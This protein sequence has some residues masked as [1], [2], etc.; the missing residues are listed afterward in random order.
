MSRFARLTVFVTVVAI[1]FAPAQ[2]GAFQTFAGDAAAKSAKSEA[3]SDRAASRDKRESRSERSGKS[4]KKAAGK[5]PGAKSERSGKS[6]ARA[7]AEANARGGSAEAPAPIDAGIGGPGVTPV[8][9]AYPAPQPV[10]PDAFAP[11]PAFPD[12]AL[13]APLVPDAPAPAFATPDPFPPGWSGDAPPPVDP[14]G[15]VPDVAAPPD[16]TPAAIDP[17]VPP[18]PITADGTTPDAPDPETDRRRPLVHSQSGSDDQ[19][20]GAGGT[21][22]PNAAALELP[23]LLRGKFGQRLPVRE[24]AVLAARTRAVE[25]A[26]ARTAPRIALSSGDGP[27]L[28]RRH[29]ISALGLTP[30]ARQTVAALGFRVLSERRSRLLGD[31]VVAKL[32]T[33]ADQSAEAALK[34][35]RALLPDVTFDYVHLYR[36]TGEQPAPVRYPVEMVGAAIDGGCRIPARIGLIDTGVARHASLAD[37]RITRRSFVD[38]DA[39]TNVAHGTAIASIL[40][41]D[42]PGTAP[43]APG[44]QLFS[45]NVFVQDAS[46]LRGDATAIIEALDWM[47]AEG[48]G[49]VNLSLIGPSNLLL[50]A[51]VAAAA[52]RGLVLVAA[53]GNDGASS[54]PAYPAAYPSVIAVAAVD[55][56][57]R[58]YG[59]G[60]RGAYIYVSAPGVDVWGADARGGEAFWTGTSFAAPFVT[61]NVARDLFLGRAHDIN[62]GRAR[63]AASARD[64]GAPGRDPIYGYGLLQIGGCSGFDGAVLS[65]RD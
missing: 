23:W 15:P 54:A 58:P 57:G 48:V 53:A 32:R 55:R 39:A 42:L 59:R 25:P 43:L 52:R 24:P 63:I 7:A 36:P 47:A 12:P 9:F 2:F 31:R 18:A 35:L 28:Y 27:D 65:A 10:G 29:E 37:A 30:S 17:S 64:L 1:T 50:E 56:R 20:S 33:P 51:A 5:G 13:G 21:N 34:R 46:G 16:P 38:A 40:V 41:G 4:S 6:G 14:N 61:A 22:A 11:A 45:G 62:D 49:V 44:A 8:S 60:N 19:R 26:T 3:S